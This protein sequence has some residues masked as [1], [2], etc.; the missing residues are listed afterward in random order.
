MRIIR[1][2][3]GTPDSAVLQPYGPGPFD[4]TYG[5]GGAGR[6]FKVIRDS[7]LAGEIGGEARVVFGRQLGKPLFLG[8][9]NVERAHKLLQ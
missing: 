4:F 1:I 9:R 7:D 8:V 5:I 6:H 3:C 2:H